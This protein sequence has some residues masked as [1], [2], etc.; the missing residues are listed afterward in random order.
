MKYTL[1]VTYF[2]SFDA[3]NKEGRLCKHN[4][5]VTYDQEGQFNLLSHTYV[6]ADY[7]EKEMNDLKLSGRTV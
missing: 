2:I 5:T 4:V 6:Y 3:F 7:K 1:G